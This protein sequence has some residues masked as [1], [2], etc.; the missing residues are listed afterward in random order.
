MYIIYIVMLIYIRV[1]IMVLNPIYND[2]QLY[3]GGQF[4]CWRKPE[5]NRLAA[6]Y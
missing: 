4:Y 6:S 3:H 2:I 1:R 5:Y